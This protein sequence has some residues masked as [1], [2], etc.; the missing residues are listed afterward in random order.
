MQ[1]K[2]QEVANTLNGFARLGQPL[3]QGAVQQLGQQLQEMSTQGVCNSCWA[4]AVATATG[5]PPAN[6]RQLWLQLNTRVRHMHKQQPD[7]FSLEDLVQLHQAQLVL[8]L[9]GHQQWFSLPEGITAAAKQRL[10]A[11]HAQLGPA[12]SF[13]QQVARAA[14]PLVADSTSSSS[15]TVHQELL[16]PRLMVPVDVAFEYQGVPVALQADGPYHFTINQP[17]TAMG[18]ALLRDFLLQRL[19]WCVVPVPWWEW[20]RLRGQQQQQQY[21]QAEVDSA[22]QA[23]DASPAAAAMRQQAL[24]VLRSGGMQGAEGLGVDVPQQAAGDGRIY[25]KWQ[26]QQEEKEEEQP[27]K[28][29]ARRAQPAAAVN[30]RSRRAGAAGA[31]PAEASSKPGR[32]KVPGQGSR[33]AAAA[34]TQTV[35]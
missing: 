33:R 22:V 31:E 1:L 16:D 30:R 27:S 23:A 35:T 9:S 11:E 17:Y 6:A 28:A 7:R 14:Q 26:Q 34:P 12:S 19:G 18:E 32:T 2:P 15:A 10:R 25:T 3:P 20:R 5:Q 8:Q 24:Q 21:L 4:L 29:A 13:Q